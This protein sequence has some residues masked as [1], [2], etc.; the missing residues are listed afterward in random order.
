MV[1]IVHDEAGSQVRNRFEQQLIAPLLEALAA[2]P[3][4]LGPVDGL[5]VV[6]PHRAQRAALREEIPCLSERDPRTGAIAVSAV[7]T[8]ERFQGGE[9]TA[10]LVS[11]TE[12]DR[13][14]LM[15]SS[16]FLLDPRRLTVALS[17]AKRKI[18]LV[19]SESVFNLFSADEETFAHAQLWKHLL[20]RTCTVP[21]WTGTQE[22][23]RVRVF[24]NVPMTD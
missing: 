19:A 23:K 17:R 12:S 10:I 14:Y 15:T 5:G 21:L 11:A 18:I 1:V 22:G 2:P 4:G 16:E 24:G 6:V 3:Y 13:A 20:E 8:V 7:D 9:R